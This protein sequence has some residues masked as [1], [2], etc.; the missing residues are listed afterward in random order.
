MQEPQILK[1]QQCPICSKNTLNLME[2]EREI[3]FFG[4]CFLF[5]MT[6]SNCK[7]RKADIESEEKH[8][9]AKYSLDIGSEEDLKIR[10]VRSAEG[11]I[12]I[13]HMITL[14]GGETANG[15]ITNVEGV[16]NRMKKVIEFAR[17][18]EED[19]D[20]QKK[21]K[22][23]LKKLNKVLWG[24]EKLKLIIEDKTG[25]SAIISEKA[26]KSKL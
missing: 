4:R 3:P 21:A 5:S 1:G 22:N 2:D 25:N 23:Q 24:Q 14:E 6:C 18:N 17:D 10:I 11:T 20:L 16:L 19:K 9:P 26:V 15:F 13:P 7:Y 12:K 8:E